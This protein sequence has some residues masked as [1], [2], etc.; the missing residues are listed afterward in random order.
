MQVE[1]YEC[2]LLLQNEMQV[3]DTPGLE[4]QKNRTA[5]FESLPLR[6]TVCSAEKF[7]SLFPENRAKPRQ[8]ASFHCQT[9]LEKVHRV[10][11]TPQRSACF[12]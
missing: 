9:G 1:F 5:G 8:F 7:A 10:S 11:V 3:A 4:V 6:H 2:M 12:L